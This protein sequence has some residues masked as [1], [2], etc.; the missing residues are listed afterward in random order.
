MGTPSSPELLALHAVRVSGMTDA[1]GIARRT[2]LGRDLAEELLLD[3]EALG[4]VRRVAFA[5]LAGWSLT[6]AGR[7]EG[8][9]LLE[10]E[11][12]R[13]GARR[14]VEDAHDTFARLNE[15]FL[16]TVTRWQIRPQPGDRLAANEHDD[17]VWDGRVLDELASYRRRLGPLCSPLRG[18]LDRFAG[19][20]D[21]YAAALARAEAGQLTWVDGAGVDSCH[22]VWIQLH[23]DLLATLGLD[24]GAAA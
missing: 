17:P 11:L 7:L 19:Y 24:R 3:D 6:D 15:R 18:A 13:T 12:D 22:T 9:R 4:W 10:E 20:D 14:A 23:E 1:A 21:R 8:E 16:S 5:D 2:G